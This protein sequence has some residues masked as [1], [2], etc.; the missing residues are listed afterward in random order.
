MILN[1][2]EEKS[3]NR[4]QRKKWNRKNPSN[5]IFKNFYP[6]WKVNLE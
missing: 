3:D 4:K 5:D 1:T 2:Q 6:I